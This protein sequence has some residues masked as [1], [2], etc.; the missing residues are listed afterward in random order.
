[1]QS[2]I[3][4][5]F[6]T[7]IETPLGSMT[8]IADDNGL[9]LLEFSDQP[10]LKREI[11]FLKKTLN[12]EILLGTSTIL[13]HVA[14]DLNNYFVNKHFIFTTPYHLLGSSFQKRVWQQLI[15]IPA[16]KTQ[17]YGEI[18]SR[19]N[20]PTAYRAVAKAN[21]TNRLAIIIPCHRV[22]NSNGQLGGYAG[23]VTRK[24]WLLTHEQ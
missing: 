24:E 18:A 6:T 20:Y 3:T 2:S 22:I 14:F 23:G 13:E 19:L 1:M 12:T 11:A 5:L 15:K 8:A 7:T 21:S 9:Y 4:Q 16:G 10:T 17:S